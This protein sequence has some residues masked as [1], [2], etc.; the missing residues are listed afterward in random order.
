MNTNNIDIRIL[1]DDDPLWDQI[2]SNDVFSIYHTKIWK[3]ITEETFKHRGIYFAAS[4]EGHLVDVLPSF[5]IKKSFMGKKI[6]STPYEGCNGGFSSSDI[7]AREMLIRNILDHAHKLGVKYVEIRSKHEIEDLKKFNFI[8]QKP[9]LISEVPLKDLDENWKMLSS[10]HRRNV[11]IARKK[12]IVVETASNWDD[13]NRFYKINANHYKALG[14]PFFGEEFFK[15]IWEKLVQNN[16]GHLLLAKYED[17]VIGGHL[18][19]FSGRTLVSKY[20]AVKKDK[21]FS[22]LNASY[23]LFW[24]GIRVGITNNFSSFN[25]GVTGESN[26]GLLDFKSRFGSETT[27]VYFY[28]YPIKGKAPDFEKYYGKYSLA[29]KVWASTPAFITSAIGQKVNEWIC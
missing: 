24:E 3:G 19:F 9:L 11:R 22:K 6:V 17:K 7:N 28:Y 12:G 14:V 20:S 2:D 15:Q 1:H 26:P 23:A 29:K 10:K 27:P 4:K 8:E 21:K 25:L 5:L 13:M 16:H 18:L